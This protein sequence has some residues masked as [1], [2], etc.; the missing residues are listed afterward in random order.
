MCLVKSDRVNG[1][2]I[3][4]E[5]AIFIGIGR[6]PRKC[7]NGNDTPPVR[8]YSDKENILTL[9][10][11]SSCEHFAQK[12]CEGWSPRA[13]HSHTTPSTLTATSSDNTFSPLI[14]KDGH[15]RSLLAFTRCNKSWKFTRQIRHHFLAKKNQKTVVE[16]CITWW[17]CIKLG[18]EGEKILRICE[19]EGDL[20]IC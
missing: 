18:V 9:D 14:T 17:R 13:F 4:Y 11:F 10:L 16:C 1:L 2:V 12:Y 8:K 19:R 7:W 3:A 20:P 15:H 5:A 6:T